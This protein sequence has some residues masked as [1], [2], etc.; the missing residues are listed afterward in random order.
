MKVASGRVASALLAVSLLWINPCGMLGNA[1][2]QEPEAQEPAG[3]EP[4]SQ[5]DTG[6]SAPSSEQAGAPAVTMES[7]RKLIRELNSKN[8]KDR[9]EAEKNLIAMGPA[10]LG[11]LPEVDANTSGEMKVR[12]QRIRQQMQSKNI[13]TFFEHSKVTL[14][15]KMKLTEAIEAIMKQTGNKIVL[16]AKK[17]SKIPKSNWMKTNRLSGP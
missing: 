1:K 16:S 15:G 12:L 10:A 9:D 4:A 6:K 2:A 17:F 14:S 11:F 5:D 13:E 7:V 3:Q 8:L